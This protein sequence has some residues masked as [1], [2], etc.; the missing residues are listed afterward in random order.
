MKQNLFQ[1]LMATLWIIHEFLTI[2]F[3]WNL[4]KLHLE[5]QL[6][7]PRHIAA[8]LPPS[9]SSEVWRAD[10]AYG[11]AT[12]DFAS[13]FERTSVDFGFERTNN[14]DLTSADLEVLP[15]CYD[16][17][18]DATDSRQSNSQRRSSYIPPNVKPFLVSDRTSSPASASDEFIETAERYIQRQNSAPMPYIIDPCRT[19][20]PFN[21]RSRSMGNYLDYNSRSSFNANS[22]NSRQ[23]IVRSD[24]RK[25]R[26]ESPPLQKYPTTFSKPVH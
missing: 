25:H 24:G 1:L 13:E 11:R 9:S 23:F 4:P 18:D 22:E 8:T 20:T 15:E 10:I 21:V 3:Y 19:S 6:E 2:F 7:E 17:D 16:I 26:R 5:E 12:P 14:P